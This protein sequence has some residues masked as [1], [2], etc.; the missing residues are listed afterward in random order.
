MTKKDMEDLKQR[1]VSDEAFRTS[2]ISDLERVLAARG[3]NP[4][5]T[6]G[7]AETKID[8]AGTTVNASFLAYDSGGHWKWV[9]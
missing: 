8:Q 7:L 1:V 3:I 5:T 9:F 6:A 4:S 2:L